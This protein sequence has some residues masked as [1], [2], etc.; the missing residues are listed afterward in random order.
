MCAFFEVKPN[1][2]LGDSGPD[3][4]PT[5]QILKHLNSA[6]HALA[7]AV[8]SGNSIEFYSSELSE[9]LDKFGV[10]LPQSGYSLLIK[11]D[12]NRISTSIAET[13]KNW[14]VT[15]EIFTISVAPPLRESTGTHG[16]G[17]RQK[18]RESIQTVGL[19]W[20]AHDKPFIIVNL[21][22]RYSGLY[23]KLEEALTLP[24]PVNAISSFEL[25]ASPN[26]L[27]MLTR[28]ANNIVRSHVARRWPDFVPQQVESLEKLLE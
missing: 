3:L 17:E 19:D 12:P 20:D 2:T 1:K 26:W 21:W 8:D 28:A 16:S 7:T 10:T 23:F 11:I 13:L 18:M 9:V 4:M 14:G 6:L 15:G 27:G 25:E 5:P 22:G 24:L